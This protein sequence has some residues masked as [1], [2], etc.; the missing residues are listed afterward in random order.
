MAC[1]LFYIFSAGR[2]MDLCTAELYMGVDY[3]PKHKESIS[4]AWNIAKQS[5]LSNL[6]SV[7]KHMVVT[8]KVR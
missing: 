8:D 6:L 1:Y 3:V 5:R 7:G 4:F 2:H